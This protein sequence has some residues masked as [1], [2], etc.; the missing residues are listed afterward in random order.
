M[1][2]VGTKVSEL[3]GYEKMKDGRFYVP[4]Q[5]RLALQ[6]GYRMVHNKENAD[7]VIGEWIKTGLDWKLNSYEAKQLKWLANIAITNFWV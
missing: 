7:D 3:E 1:N 6:L 2:L 4:P 5:M